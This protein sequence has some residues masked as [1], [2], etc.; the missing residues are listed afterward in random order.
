MKKVIEGTIA[1]LV[2]VNRSNKDYCEVSDLV[3]NWKAILSEYM[4]THYIR[5]VSYEVH[6]SYFIAIDTV[7]KDFIDILN[8]VNIAIYSIDYIVDT[9]MICFKDESSRD[10]VFNVIKK[11]VA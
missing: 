2:Y 9:I 1:G 11:E 10:L 4:T 3:P 8:K 6:H 5:Y 7:D